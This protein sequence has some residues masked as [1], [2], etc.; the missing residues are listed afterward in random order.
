MYA[1]KYL[2]FVHNVCYAESMQ[3]TKGIYFLH[4]EIFKLQNIKDGYVA[5]I[6]EQSAFCVVKIS[7]LQNP[8]NYFLSKTS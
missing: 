8:L 3:V 7:R 1:L 2:R 4:W 5:T 6:M